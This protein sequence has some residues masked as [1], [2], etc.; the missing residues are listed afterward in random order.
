[1]DGLSIGYGTGNDRPSIALD[2]DVTTMFATYSMG[3]VSVGYQG[4]YLNKGSAPTAGDT[5]PGADYSGDAIGIAFNVNDNVSIG[6]QKVSETQEANAAGA[7]S[8]LASDR[9]IKSVS[10]THLTLPTKA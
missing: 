5:S 1:M 9:D 3:P 10:Y 4:Y 8:V 2:N 7:T 6:Y